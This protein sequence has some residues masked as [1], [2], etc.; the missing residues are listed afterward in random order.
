[1]PDFDTAED[2]ELSGIITE[3]SQPLLSK[4]ESVEKERDSL[5]SKGIRLHDKLKELGY[6]SSE[7][8]FDEKFDE[9]VESYKSLLREVEELR[10]ILKELPLHDIPHSVEC[11]QTALYCRCFHSKIHSAIANQ[12]EQI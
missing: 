11:Q 12:K 3:K 7:Q 10:D 9:M 8:S 6:V 1:V 4:L 5:Q 2:G